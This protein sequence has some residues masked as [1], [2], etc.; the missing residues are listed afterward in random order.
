[1]NLAEVMERMLCHT[2]GE[3][4]RPGTDR[5]IGLIDFETFGEPGSNDRR[6]SEDA[7]MHLECLLA[8]CEGKLYIVDYVIHTL[9]VE[10]PGC[11]RDS[12][13][14]IIHDFVLVAVLQQF[15]M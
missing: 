10:L 7:S 13:N 12:R 5:L 3:S 15:K 1:M 2:C 6:L 14:I 9:L 4:N 8:D 11:A